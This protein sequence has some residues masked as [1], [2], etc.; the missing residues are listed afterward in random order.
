MTQGV[1]PRLSKYNKYNLDNMYKIRV[2]IRNKAVLIDE[3]VFI[4]IELPSIPRKGE[5]VFLDEKLIEELENKAK[6]SLINSKSYAPK[7]FYGTSYDCNDP[8]K[9]NLI[10][11][12]FI[13]AKFVDSVS[14][15][16]NSDIVHV[17]LKC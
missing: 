15:R 1:L 10:D 2:H 16:A 6:S 17:E 9:E 3:A 5:I 12:S 7:W 13:D 4:D 14:Y 11:L 8:K